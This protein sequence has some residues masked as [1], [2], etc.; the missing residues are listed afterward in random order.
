MPLKEIESSHW[1]LSNGEAAHSW[2]GKPTDLR[3]AKKLQRDKGMSLY[4]SVTNLL[5]LLD[6]PGLNRWRVGNGITATMK[7]LMEGGM[8]N[9]KGKT[10]CNDVVDATQVGENFMQA[11]FDR[12]IADGRGASDFG[13][14]WHA[15]AEDINNGKEPAEDLELEPFVPF[16][17]A[18]KDQQLGTIHHAELRV[19]DKELGF[20]GTADLVCELH[21]YPDDIFVL[22][23]KTTGKEP[24]KLRA[25]PEH[26]Y[27]LAAYAHAVQPRFPGKT[28]RSGNVM[29]SSITPAEPKLCLWTIAQQGDGLQVFKGITSIWQRIKKYRP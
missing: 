6:K 25:F 26:C 4:P 12:A 17:R 11:A 16:Y 14:R 18:W 19:V 21:D 29:V 27:Q 3:V 7:L 20:A 23:F 13:T 8:L 9:E 2:E 15:M 24:K 22:D 28:I 10:L 5:G 1:Y